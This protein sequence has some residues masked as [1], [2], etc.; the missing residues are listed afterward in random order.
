VLAARAA[1]FRERFAAHIF[2]EDE[3]RLEHVLG[4]QLIASNITLSPRESCTGGGVAQ[5]ITE[6]PGISQVFRES[7]VTYADESKLQ[8]LG[9]PRAL[10]DQHGAVSS[11][12][13]EVDGARRRPRKR[14]ASRAVRHG[15]RRPRRRIG[16]QTRRPGVYAVRARRGGAEFRA[17]LPADRSRGDPLVCVHTAL[18]LLWRACSAAS[19]RGR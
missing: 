4:R 2:S 18:E 9:V 7:W 11:A 19:S 10:L 12:V 15:H 1:E 13:A 6:V 17:A 5:R 14:R 16:G 3:P 8:R